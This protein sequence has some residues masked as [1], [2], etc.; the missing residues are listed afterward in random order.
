M[1]MGTNFS[2]KKYI[3]RGV[4]NTI[5]PEIQIAMFLWL[6]LM[7]SKAGELDYLQIFRLETI[8]KD[9]KLLLHICHE[10]EVPGAKLDYLISVSEELNAKVYIIDDGEYVTMLLAEEY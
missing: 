1:T 6:D 5:P 4:N 8:E 3:T 9:G 7:R 10:Q 2:G